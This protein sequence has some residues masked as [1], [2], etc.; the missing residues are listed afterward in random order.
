MA[1]GAAAIHSLVPFTTPMADSAWGEMKH[2]FGTGMNAGETA[3]NVAGLV[4]APEV[5]EGLNAV[6]TFD[7]TREANAAK[8]MAQGFDEPTARYLSKPY[9]GQAEHA[10]IPQRQDSIAGVPIPGLR[11]VP[12]PDWI[13]DSPL[14]VSRPRG[15]SQGDF[16]EYHFGVDPHFYGAGLPRSLNGGKGWSG[17]RLGME[18]Y[19][20]AGRMW[21]RTPQVWKDYYTGVAL[22]D[23][24][25]QLPADPSEAPQ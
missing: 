1:G 11:N 21:A 14:N 22:G 3:A 25:G 20:G 8:F 17:K 19:S 18:R 10:V 16:Y 13:M 7:A 15:M 2:E 23:A 24:L 6:R 9:A 5:F 12:I 4:A